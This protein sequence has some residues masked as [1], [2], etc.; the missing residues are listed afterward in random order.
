MAWYPCRFTGNGYFALWVGTALLLKL[1]GDASAYADSARVYLSNERAVSMW[2]QVLAGISLSIAVGF[3]GDTEQYYFNGYWHY[4]LA[5]GIV[6]TVFAFVGAMLLLNPEA[7]KPVCKAGTS[8]QQTYS[9]LIAMFLFLWWVV[10]VGVITIMG[11]FE[12][13]R[14]VSA[15]G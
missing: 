15:N 12:N 8:R 5:V 2:G 4:A 1:S 10:G 9:G 14:D 7:D 11:P 3:L 13:T 6:A